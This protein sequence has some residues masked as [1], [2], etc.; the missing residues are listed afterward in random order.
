MAKFIPLSVMFFRSDA[1]ITGYA[2]DAIY[3]VVSNE[4]SEEGKQMLNY[5]KDETHCEKTGLMPMR[6]QRCRSASQ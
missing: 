4:P 1:E 3:N 2:L 5:R 6:K